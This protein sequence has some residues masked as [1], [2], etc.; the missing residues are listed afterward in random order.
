VSNL[1]RDERIDGMFG[2]T[3]STLFPS[4]K[5]ISGY[6]NFS[7]SSQKSHKSWFRK[8]FSHLEELANEPSSL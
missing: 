1:N 5:E 3:P 2:K 8:Y 6:E 4:A 7:H